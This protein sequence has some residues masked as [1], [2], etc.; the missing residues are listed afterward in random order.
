MNY[1][2]LLITTPSIFIQKILIRI[3]IIVIDI[4]KRYYDLINDVRFHENN[5]T[6]KYS[7]F[8][9]TDYGDIF[10]KSELKYI[11]QR[12]CEHRFD[13]LGTGWRKNS[14]SAK[15]KGFEGYVYNNNIQYHIDED[16]D[17]LNRLLLPAHIRK[18]KDIWKQISSEYDPI[19]WQMDFKSGFIWSTKKWY[20]NQTYGRRPGADIKVPWELAR[21]QHLP[22]LAICAGVLEKFKEALINEFKNQ[23]LDFIATNP[24]RMGVNWSCTMDV[25]IRAANMLIACD[26]FKQIDDKGILDND[27]IRI[28]VNSIHQHGLHIVNNLE[29]GK[30]LTTNHYLSN[31]GGLLFIAAYLECTPET[32]QWLSFSV[33]E[34]IS[35]VKKQF[36]NDGT[37]F[38]A[39]TSYHRL[40]AEIVIYATAL[41][42]GLPQAKKNVLSCYNF[43]KWKHQPHL[44]PSPIM[45]YILPSEN[46]KKIRT[47]EK[48]P[49]PV[50]YFERLERM[51]E[52]TMNITKPNGNIHQVGDNDSGRFFKLHPV[53]EK[54]TVSEAKAKYKNLAGYDEF[55]DTH[56]YLD[57]NILDH[58][59]LVAAI[60]SLFNRKDFK[61]FSGSGWIDGILIRQLS[62]GIRVQSYHFKK[63]L[64]T[65]A[66]IEPVVNSLSPEIKSENYYS[67]IHA[68]PIPGKALKGLKLYTYPDFGL[69][70]YK[71]PELYCAIRC[72]SVG[73]NGNGGH[74][75]N[76]NLSIE[77][78]INK[79]DICIDPGSYIYTALPDMRNKFRSIISHAVPI[80]NM[81]EQNSWGNG[82]HDLFRIKER[83]RYRINKITKNKLCIT[84]RYDT[85]FQTR[86]IEFDGENLIV[87]DRCNKPFSSVIPWN[88]Q[89]SNGY[90]KMTRGL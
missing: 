11:S 42:L 80:V 59:H 69:Y 1:L 23:I 67:F 61:Q 24:P 6:I 87:Q 40:S 7:Y 53:Y 89:C 17:F 41:V 22:Q 50:W 70:I 86:S 85:I 37:N 51:A 10:N 19:N 64:N 33:Q 60:N 48:S 88:T 66:V 62:Q 29:Y 90:G 8:I 26:M 15:P 34:L 83:V 54:M 14:Y 18:S 30:R 82:I 20:K 31:I 25:A 84:L 16:G 38:E 46:N 44:V 63:N 2:K 77:L 9:I 81:H 3:K 5:I 55:P 49:F 57:E 35:E 27:F 74:A 75:H 21:L 78:N 45:H 79:K 58:R 56:I 36:Y 39:S 47:I 13:L 76:D 68:I 12:F 28:F 73:Q 52:F 65:H 32:D 72:G 4:F 43:K 71:S